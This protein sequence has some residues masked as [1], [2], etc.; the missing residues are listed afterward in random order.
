MA[1][2]ASMTLV[3]T[4]VLWREPYLLAGVLAC[5]HIVV[6]LYLQKRR[7][8]FTYLFGFVLGP[9]A[10]ALSIAAGAWTYT[11]PQFAGV[12]VW[13]PFLWGATTLTAGY[14]ANMRTAHE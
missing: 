12:P 11:L 6:L 8:L 13:L 1:A 10:E 4:I 2:F 5:F 3:L 9:I 7:F 14:F